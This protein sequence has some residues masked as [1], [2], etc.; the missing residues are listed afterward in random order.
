MAIFPA[1]P[2]NTAGL[3]DLA[4]L[5]VGQAPT[6][7]QL[8][9]YVAE[10]GL[11]RTIALRERRRAERFEGIFALLVVRPTAGAPTRVV[12]AAVDAV[13]AAKRETEFVG[14]LPATPSLGL[15]CVDAGSAADIRSVER[16]I[17]RE[18]Q[19]RAGERADTLFTFR[20]HVEGA[21]GVADG[22]R[23]DG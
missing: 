23:L 22:E 9:D 8:R 18:I 20:R 4:T 1:S 16:R 19:R 13:C 2:A 3:R 7:P 12:R 21:P 6:A 5:S 11:F 15:L 17:R 10:P 14:W